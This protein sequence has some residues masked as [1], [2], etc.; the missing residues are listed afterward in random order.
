MRTKNTLWMLLG[1][2]AL[3][4]GVS[5]CDEDPAYQEDNPAACKTPCSGDTPYCYEG[6]CVACE[7][8]GF[9]AA[10]QNVPFNQPGE[11]VADEVAAAKTAM[12]NYYPQAAV[13]PLATLASSGVHACVPTQ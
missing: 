7:N 3:G 13:C 11:S 4:I 8:N 2:V 10:I 1:L 12:T 6:Q 9:N 5:A